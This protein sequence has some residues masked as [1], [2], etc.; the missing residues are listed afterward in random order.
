MAPLTETAPGADDRCIAPAASHVSAVPEG[1]AHATGGATGSATSAA[2][3]SVLPGSSFGVGLG[4]KGF[5]AEQTPSL[6]CSSNAAYSLSPAP[7]EKQMAAGSMPENGGQEITHALGVPDGMGVRED[8]TDG[9][10]K[11]ID[12]DRHSVPP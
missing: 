6:S 3:S 10:E 7:E 2:A 9:V 12:G 1:A 4:A 11:S 8:G 5:P